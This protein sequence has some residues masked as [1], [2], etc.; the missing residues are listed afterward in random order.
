[1]I[2]ALKGQIAWSV[3]KDTIRTSPDSYLIVKDDLCMGVY[4]KIPE[5]YDGITVRDCGTCLIIPGMTDLHT[6]A[7]QYAIRGIGMDT[8]LLPWLKTYT[9]P[10]E[11]K[12]S[13]LPYA[14][15]EYSLF[16][17]EM[18]RGWTTRVCIFATLHTQAT[19]ELMNL[20]EETGL[21]SYVGRVNMDRDGGENLCEKDAQTALQD[22]EQWIQ[23]Y[24]HQHHTRTRMILTPRFIPSCSDDLMK[25]I[26]DLAEKYHLR[27]QSHLSEN[28]EE[29]RLVE[30]LVPASEGYADAYERFGS[31][32][33]PQHPSIMAHCVYTTDEEMEVLRK[34]GTYIAHCPGSNMNLSSGIAPAAKY[35][36]AGIHI[37]LG[38]DIGAGESLLMPHQIVQA[39]QVSNLYTRLIDSDLEPLSFEEAFWMATAGGGSYFGKTGTFAKGSDADILVIDDTAATYDRVMDIRLRLERA[40]YLASECRILSKYVAGRR[41]L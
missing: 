35:L 24:A 18:R 39:L 17:D 5:E 37:G 12:F 38:T 21:I 15:K 2:F 7:S 36:R 27:I 33:D 6:H 16:A 14:D 28:P 11:A 34:H 41:I 29:I 26:T 1:M 9:F 30:K 32:Q 8:Q 20:M 31:L 3:D 4:E 23:E 40:V 25:G 19:E 13:S 22:T 10:E